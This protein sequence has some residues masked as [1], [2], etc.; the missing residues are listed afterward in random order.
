MSNTQIVYRDLKLQTILMRIVN[1]IN[2]TID[3]RQLKKFNFA[4]QIKINRYSNVK[5]L[6]RKF[7]SLLQ[8]FQNQKRFIVNVKKI[9]LYDYYRQ[10]Y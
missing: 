4:Q 6:R 10:I 2:R 3:S 5:I 8:I 1:E 9:F 7:K